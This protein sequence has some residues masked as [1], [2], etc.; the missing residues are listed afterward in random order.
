M[1]WR[2]KIESQ[3]LPVCKRVLFPRGV[4][5]DSTHLHLVQQTKVLC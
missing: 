2:E 1:L 4:G 5:L 3:R